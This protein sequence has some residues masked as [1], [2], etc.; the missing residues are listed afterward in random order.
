MH[1]RYMHISLVCTGFS[2][3][4]D[5]SVFDIESIFGLAAD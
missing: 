5:S 1:A 4:Y 3:V 2:S